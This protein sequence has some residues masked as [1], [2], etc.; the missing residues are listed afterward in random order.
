VWRIGI[1]KT[2]TTSEHWDQSARSLVDLIDSVGYTFDPQ[3]FADKVAG[4]GERAFVELITLRQE[5][6]L[7][8]RAEIEQIP[9]ARALDEVRDLAPTANFARIILGTVGDATADLI[10][11][12]GGSIKAGDKTGL[13]GL[14]RYFNSQLIGEPGVQVI[15]TNDDGSSRVLFEKPPVPGQPVETTLNQ[16]YQIAAEQALVSIDVPAAIVAI[17]PSTGEVVVAANGP[18]AT[19]NIALLGQYP[20]GSTFKIV[21]A[22]AFSRAGMNADS[23]V[24]CTETITVDGRVFSNVPGYPANAL[25]DV[26][27]RTAFANSCNTAFIAQ[28]SWITQTD[29][30]Q[31]AQAFG[32]GESSPLGLGAFFGSVPEDATGTTLAANLLGQGNILASPLAMARVAA[33]VMASGRVDPVLVRGSQ[34]DSPNSSATISD[35]EAALL[36]DLMA[37][38]VSEGSAQVLAD[39]PGIRGAKTGTAQFGD[40]TQ[41]HTWMLAIVDTRAAADFGLA[42]DDLA[43][44]V[45]VE[46][47]E[48]GATTSGPIMHEFLTAVTQG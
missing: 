30:Q 17:R 1:D 35:D 14:Q 7:I 29:L 6:S 38:V 27:L 9:G 3:T 19:S 15:T 20:P 34:T 47:G 10:E 44:A 39:I 23:V 25:G 45:F 46:I 48:Y 2:F 12:S 43:V 8:T 21:D 37:A 16:R 31:A 18:G 11:A 13:S 28:N 26:P 22:L 24:P 33:T 36:A 42:G 5:N 40:G 41:N 32:L 4:A